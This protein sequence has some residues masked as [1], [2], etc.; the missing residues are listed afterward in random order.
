MCLHS[1][2]RC[3]L[4]GAGAVLVHARVVNIEKA[5]QSKMTIRIKLLPSPSL[6]ISHVTSVETPMFFFISLSEEGRRRY[7][8]HNLGRNDG[9]V[10][11]H[12][13]VHNR[14]THDTCYV[15][16]IC[17]LTDFGLS[18]GKSCST[19]PAAGTKNGTGCN[20]TADTENDC[21]HFVVV[22][23]TIIVLSLAPLAAT[24]LQLALGW[25]R[26]TAVLAEGFTTR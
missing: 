21:E 7:A 6:P 4:G 19:P 5:G 13:H 9:V 1:W 23:F 18:F 2:L 24:P 14:L 12:V 8:S 11:L 25:L 15:C 20:H 26:L 3:A 16:H 17:F 10:L 22:S